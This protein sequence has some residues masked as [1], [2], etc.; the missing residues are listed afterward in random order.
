MSPEERAAVHD[1]SFPHD[2]GGKCPLEA[3]LSAYED[4]RSSRMILAFYVVVVVAVFVVAVAFPHAKLYNPWSEA[5]DS[6]PLF[7][8][9][10]ASLALVVSGLMLLPRFARE[11]REN[12]LIATAGPTCNPWRGVEQDPRSRWS[13]PLAASVPNLLW[14]LGFHRLAERRRRA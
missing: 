6:M 7:V 13:A 14:L 3:A 10:L 2:P 5:E 4:D 12:H 1:G 8:A 11:R 9:G